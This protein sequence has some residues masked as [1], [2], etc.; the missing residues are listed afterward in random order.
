[1]SLTIKASGYPTPVLSETGTLPSG[2]T[3]TDNRN[4]T[5]TI[6]GT[7]TAGSAGTYQVMLTAASRLGNASQMFTLTV[8]SK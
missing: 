6:S 4:G 8:L 7:P 1:M 3:F 2:L 5:A